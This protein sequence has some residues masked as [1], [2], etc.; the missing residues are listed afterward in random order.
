LLKFFWKVSGSKKK[1][2]KGENVDKDLKS[3]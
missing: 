1:R 2:E 3:E